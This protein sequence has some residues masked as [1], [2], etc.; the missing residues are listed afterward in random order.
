MDIFDGQYIQKLAYKYAIVLLVVG[1]L[2][3]LSIG[4]FRVNLLER[5][6]GRGR[7]VRAVYVLVGISALAIMFYRD[8]YLPFLGETV[9]PCSA[10]KEQTPAGAD[11][12][13][14]VQVRPGVK[15]IYW[16]SEPDK[17][18]LSTLKN[19]RAAYLKFENVGVVIA[20]KKGDAVLRVRKPQPYT[21]PIR[22]RLE[23]HIHY[24]VCGD[25]RGYAMLGRVE[26]VFLT[27]G[28]GMQIAQAAEGFT[29]AQF[30]N[31][32]GEGKLIY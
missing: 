18:H 32:D 5:L 30:E 25:E 20:D 23:P 2:L 22:G 19:W 21:V 31:A 10:L 14:H 6:L 28:G 17:E 12:E 13:L 11:T 15:V 24:R 8:T 1:A 16:A 29:D 7:A 27:R 9:M 26:T 3:W 4:I